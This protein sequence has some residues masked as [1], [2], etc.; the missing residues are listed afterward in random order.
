MQSFGHCVHLHGADGVL[1]E[2]CYFTGALRPTNDIFKET[3]GRAVEY[4]F[5]IMYRGER[6]IPQD[7]M[8]PL[9][10]D[11]V[12]SYGGDRNVRVVN[13]TVERM[14]GCFQLHCEGEV[15]LE[16]VTVREAGDFAYDVSNGDQGPV[17]LKNCKS[18]L[19]YNPIFNLTRGEVPTDA[20]YEIAV[21]SPREG[22]EPTERT[23][24]GTICGLRS[25]FILR[26]GMTRPVPHEAYRLNCGGPHGLTQSL[27]RNYT[28]A[29]LVLDKQVR[30]CRIESVGEVEDHGERNRVTQ[31]V[32]RGD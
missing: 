18:D 22:I 28:K 27:I 12:R 32:L 4:D 29:T 7:Q 11:G 23:S 21:L 26:D 17:I 8:I 5:K 2:N 24:L 1:I 9:T 14:R 31:V 3:V 20:H 19:A 6:P 16:N 10:E 25:T 15:T 30:D 13:T